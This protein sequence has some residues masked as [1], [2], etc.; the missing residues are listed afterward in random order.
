M[1]PI[2]ARRSSRTILPLLA[3][4][5]LPSVAAAD[6]VSSGIVNLNIPSTIDGLSLNLVTGASSTTDWVTGWDF[7][8]YTAETLQCDANYSTPQAGF[9]RGF[10]G[11]SGVNNLP[12]GTVIGPGGQDVFTS[13]STPTS[14]QAAA[15]WILSSGDNYAGV[16]FLDEITGQYH[17]GWIRF[18]VADTFG[19]QP[20]SI[21]EYAYED[22]PNTAI[23]IG[24]GGSG[25]PANCG[26]VPTCVELAACGQDVP[27]STTIECVEFTAS[28][29]CGILILT[30]DWDWR[31]T[32]ALPWRHTTWQGPAGT[33]VPVSILGLTA[34]TFEP[35]SRQITVE[36]LT[37]RNVDMNP[38]GSRFRFRGDA[39][40]L[41][42]DNARFVCSDQSP[43]WNGLAPLE[44]NASHGVNTLFTLSGNINPVTSLKVASGTTMRFDFC[45]DTAIG[46][47]LS[48]RCNF[49]NPANHADIDGGT[50]DL[51][52]SYVRFL[53]EDGDM[54]VRNGGLLQ[55]SGPG[56]VL[57]TDNLRIVD[58]TVRL[59]VA[60]ALVDA[61][62]LT[63]ENATVEF[64]PS[65][66][67]R[68]EVTKV[69]GA[70]T[71]DIDG[72]SGTSTGLF[73][74]V[75]IEGE[76]STLTLSGD[77]RATLEFLFMSTPF[78]PNPRL[79]LTEAADLELTNDN[80]WRDGSVEILG[81]GS[82]LVID[83]GASLLSSIPIECQAGIRVG[84]LLVAN[85]T[86]SGSG[87]LDVFSEGTL[88]IRGSSADSLTVEPNI[89]LYPVSTF[90]VKIDPLQNRSQ[91]LVANGGVSMGTIGAYLNAFVT[92]STDVVLPVG[93]KFGIL[94][95]P[96][97]A[98]FIGYFWKS[99]NSGD[100]LSGDLITIG[101]N[102]YRI[103]YYD[104][105]FDPKNP[106][107]VT[108]TVV[109]A[110]NCPA[111]LNHDG[112]VDGADLSLLLQS[113]GP[114]GSGACP[115]DLNGSG[116]V[117]GADL[118]ILLN[119]WGNCPA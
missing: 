20:R 78:S 70:T 107:M 58:S 1:H 75:A 2:A 44:I 85:G 11:A 3:I 26:G 40:A 30:D 109:P 68:T 104:T 73:G 110:T 49:L 83:E 16:R 8:F 15:N 29:S 95:Y 65:S 69:V 67:I 10:Q 37:L 38:G 27:S 79:V 57:E 77:G 76:G 112:M 24:A 108:L 72:A 103:A 45:G 61:D 53:N 88:G 7:Q 89:G 21:V 63:L 25:Q 81:V 59:G 117:D 92:S 6:V 54:V 113:W 55:L 94:D 12:L 74:S 98:D 82:D 80:D 51:Y 33:Q 50:L 35:V 28:P 32:G 87:V 4:A 36:T 66:K 84:G 19:G 47:P 41:T 102:T 13:S 118:S 71:L 42:L 5:A 31:D 99:D 46:L 90:N 96:T 23:A 111:D 100:L 119:A 105:A 18:C 39:H 17:Y 48:A 22:T 60:G 93:T 97:T 62:V 9:V 101:L 114:C 115:A 56:T 86:I 64:E 52:T 91:R 116:Y 34:K 14:G 106:T 43:V